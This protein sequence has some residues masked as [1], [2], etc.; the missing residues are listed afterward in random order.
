M[1]CEVASWVIQLFMNYQ[2]YR[3]ILSSILEERQRVN[4]NY[5]LRAFAKSLDV[6]SGRLS[7]VLNGKQGLSVKVARDISQSIGFS[8]ELSEMFCLMVKAD[9]SRSKKKRLEAKSE[10]IKVM[11]KSQDG[12]KSLALEDYEILSDWYNIAILEAVELEQF[13]N[14]PQWIA[15]EFAI[16]P[17]LAK[18]A[19]DKLQQIGVLKLEK[20]K[21]VKTQK[22]L[23]IDQKI[24]DDLMKKFY[25]QILTKSQESIYLQNYNE[26]FLSSVS[27]A[28]DSQDLE[29][30]N[31][32][33][34]NF[35]TKFNKLT[36]QLASKPG[37]KK[38]QVYCFST[39][40]FKLNTGEEK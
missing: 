20:G 9:D 30:L 16:T 31:E 32:E 2:S 14:D 18:K 8:Q 6:D 4:S 23:K 34:N 22:I 21:L 5:S 7:R 10:L 35:R 26:R 11:G 1:L 24:A 40:L 27:F 19:L 38:E 25:E 15:K 12:E 29:I 39:Q 28:L 13:Q 37:R 3:D 17:L 33:I 36:E